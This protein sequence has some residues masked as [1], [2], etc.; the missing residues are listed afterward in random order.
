M[1]SQ[2]T[3]QI[4][5]IYELTKNMFL[6]HWILINYFGRK[7]TMIRIRS[8]F[9]ALLFIS[10]PLYGQWS[11]PKKGLK[12]ITN[13]EF[14]T[15]MKYLSDENK[16][17]RDTPSSE[18]DTCATYIAR[19][20]EQYGLTPVGDNENYFQYF[21]LLRNRLSQPNTLTLITGDEEKEFKLKDDFVPVYLTANTSIT[22]PVVFAGYGITAP[23][24]NYDDY[25]NI[26]VRGK[27]VLVFTHEPQ[28]KDSSSIFEGKAMTDH[29]K[30]YEKAINARGHGAVGML[31]VT[32]PNHRFRRPP[33]P[34]P[35]LMKAA[36]E[37]AI[38]LSLG[39]KKENKIV[40]MRIGKK[41]AETIFSQTGK[42]MAE[43]QTG[44][45]TTLQPHS[46]EIP[47]I[48]VN[49]QTTLKPEKYQTQNVIGLLEGRDPLQKQEYVIIGAHYDHVGV[50]NDTIVYT[51]AD[52]NAS[53]TVGLMNIAKA[54]CVAGKRPKRSIIFCAWAGEEKGLFGSR[55]YTGSDPEVLL[56]KTIAYINLDMIGRN[57]SSRVQ[58][59]GLDSSNDF[60]LILK[61][62]NKRIGLE[63]K[64]R[65]GFGGSDHLSFYRKNIPVIFFN[66][67]LHEDYHKPT[68]TW[69]KCHP[70]GAVQISKLTFKI[71]WILAEMEKPPE[72]N[73][74]EKDDL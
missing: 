37:N 60:E 53:G 67:G 6:K 33:N 21:N 44:I 36:P 5:I 69:E 57:D 1:L 15:H 59:S 9:I 14:I 31:V 47:E 70:E 19:Y 27:I 3:S 7:C 56:D 40:I 25:S 38:P 28:E 45:D 62:A 17:G 22:T 68:D 35:S 51:G 43:L 8:F 72:F 4:N 29:S 73:K 61:Q 58:V 13:V 50:R 34:W 16:K 71:A 24:Y 49:M 64:E 54:F 48:A 32:D 65:K 20:F 66:T 55:Y 52:D 18:L 74:T 26:D 46:F 39:E 41:L 12:S 30:L 42:T 23:E 11:F 63:I 2:F 10:I